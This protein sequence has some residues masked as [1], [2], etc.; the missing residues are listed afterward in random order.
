MDTRDS[1]LRVPNSQRQFASE[2]H[3]EDLVQSHVRFDHEKFLL[4]RDGQQ[5][6]GVELV[7]VHRHIAHYHLRLEGTSITF[8][9]NT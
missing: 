3:Q 4:R 1:K 2:F 7:L 6:L 9:F 8:L 5:K